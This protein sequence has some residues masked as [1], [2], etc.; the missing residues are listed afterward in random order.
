VK[1]AH[2]AIDRGLHMRQLK[3]AAAPDGK[4]NEDGCNPIGNDFCFGNYILDSRAIWA[5]KPSVCKFGDKDYEIST[6]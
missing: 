3:N 4:R 1:D 6:T 5:R 2:K